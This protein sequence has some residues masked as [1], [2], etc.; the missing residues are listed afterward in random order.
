MAAPLSTFPR[1]FWK[2]DEEI[3]STLRDVLLKNLSQ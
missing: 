1:Q 2:L 3:R